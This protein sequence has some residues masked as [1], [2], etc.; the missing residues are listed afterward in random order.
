MLPTWLPT[1]PPPL[2]LSAS[3]PLCLSASLPRALGQDSDPGRSPSSRFLLAASGL[4]VFATGWL[5]HAYRASAEPVEETTLSLA[6]TGQVYSLLLAIWTTCAYIGSYNLA[7][8]GWV[9]QR[10]P[11][12]SMHASLPL[13]GASCM[14]SF[15]VLSCLIV[16]RVLFL[17]AA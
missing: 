8:W 2:C 9:Q 13:P 6:I 10:M 15:T 3:L 7:P 11:L 14:D 17:R 5:L 16:W 12:P 4:A 1:E